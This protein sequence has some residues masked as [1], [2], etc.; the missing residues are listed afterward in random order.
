MKKI[1]SIGLVVVIILSLGAL[2]F[3]DATD[4][5]QR[6]FGRENS[7]EEFKKGSR[8]NSSSEEFNQMREDRQLNLNLNFEENG[9]SDLASITDLTEEEILNSDLT[10][11]ELAE[12]QEVLVEFKSLILEKKTISLNELVENGTISREKADFMIERMEN[13]DGSHERLGQNVTRGN[14]RHFNR[15]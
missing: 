8:R 3:A 6:G 1:L 15:K 12:E 14:G 11:H 13:S 9:A 10:L 5:F 2:S 7:S 4:T